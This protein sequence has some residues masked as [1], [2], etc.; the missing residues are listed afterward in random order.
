MFKLGN[1]NLGML[2]RRNESV[3]P[4]GR[5]VRSV[6]GNVLPGKQK[7]KDHGAVL[8]GEWG[9]RVHGQQVIIFKEKFWQA[10][11]RSLA[12]PAK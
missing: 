1:L 3:K 11:F 6:F 7:A 5:S 12:T 4:A 10:C 2:P 9:N 8:K